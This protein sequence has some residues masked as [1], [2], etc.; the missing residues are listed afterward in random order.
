M[1]RKNRNPHPPRRDD[2]NEQYDV[3]YVFLTGAPEIAAIVVPHMKTIYHNMCCAAWA[4]EV[5][6]VRDENDRYLNMIRNAI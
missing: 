4:D 1:G 6:E 3:D 2:R 5:H